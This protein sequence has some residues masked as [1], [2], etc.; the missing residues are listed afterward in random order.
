AGE[1][2][3]GD[4]TKTEIGDEPARVGIGIEQWNRYFRDRPVVRTAARRSIAGDAVFGLPELEF[5]SQRRADDR[6]QI[7]ADGPPKGRSVKRRQRQVIAGVRSAIGIVLRLLTVND[8]DV[9]SP[10]RIDVVIS[11][12]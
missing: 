10:L 12:I 4:S 9:S 3:N 8:S 6:T 1:S 5:V 7:R 11:A 2:T